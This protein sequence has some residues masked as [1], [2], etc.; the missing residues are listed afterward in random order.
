LNFSKYTSLTNCLFF[1]FRVQ[2]PLFFY[3]LCRS[4][5]VR[6]LANRGFEMSWLG[7]IIGSTGQTC[8]AGSVIIQPSHS[9]EASVAQLVRA[10]VCGTECR[11][12]KSHRSPHTKGPVFIPGFL[13]GQF[14][15]DFI[16]YACACRCLMTRCLILQQ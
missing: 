4:A 13:Y 8:F 9:D 14:M 10:S 5:R 3:V 1:D 16:G 15:V 11:G 7:G 2:L 12:F 6:Q